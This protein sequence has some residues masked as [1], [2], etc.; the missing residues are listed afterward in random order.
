[1]IS[2]NDT[3]YVLSAP[4]VITGETMYLRSRH[5]ANRNDKI[6]LHYI[7]RQL[8]NAKIFNTEEEARE[9][10][11]NWVSPNAWQI[12]PIPAKKFFTDKLKG[13]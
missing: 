12:T 9:W 11:E 8:S 4:G 10:R 6:N 1:M 5:G 7:V 13:S 3:V 2:P